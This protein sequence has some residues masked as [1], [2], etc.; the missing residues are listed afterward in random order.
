L[1]DLLKL[2]P[3]QILIRWVNYHLEKAGSKKRIGNFSGDI[4][5]SEAYTILLNQICPNG[6]C[7]LSPMSE[8][9]PSKR[10]EKML[11]QAGKINA[12][13]FVKARDVVAGNPKLN[14]AFVANLFNMYPKLD[15]VQ[16]SQYADL[17]DFDSEGSR[18]ERA[19]RMWIQSLGIDCNN[20]YED[21]KDGLCLI[22]TIDKVQPN[23]VDWKKVDQKPKM[24]VHM[25]QNNNYTLELAE[26]MAIKTVNMSGPDIHDGNKKIILALLWQLMRANL[27]NLLK[28]VGG[29]E[30]ISEDD[31]VAW[32]NKKMNG[33]MKID[34]FKDSSIKT[35]VFL[36][37]LC[38]AIAPQSVNTEFITPGENT[39]DATQNAKYAISVAR[40]I[41]APCF[42]LHDDIIEVK[43][44]MIF[45]FL[46]ALMQVDIQ[47]NGRSK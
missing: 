44:K 21:S 14:L 13:K 9:D 16:V 39:E 25:V 8:N 23:I 5:D 31:V 4:K 38:A 29:G 46:A 24:K 2:P 42:L 19:F 12:R 37:Q 43:P 6:E 28:D 30:K 41:G 34:S 35:G 18:E 10:A 20:L 47:K 3:E 7:D 17:M 1:K 11:D 45:S 32:A 22:K 40:K 26:K 15:A 36:C 33:S 27:L